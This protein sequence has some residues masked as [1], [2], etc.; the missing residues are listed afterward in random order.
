MK[1]FIAVTFCVLL[2]Q[3]LSAQQDLIIQGIVSDVPD[4]ATL[5][6]FLQ[7]GNMGVS[8]G[9]DTLRN[10]RFRFQYPL[11]GPERFSIHRKGAEHFGNDY[12]SSVV[13][14]GEP[15]STV[16]V[17]GDSPFVRTWKVESDHPEQL[18]RNRLTDES[19]EAYIRLEK[20]DNQ[21]WQTRQKRNVAAPEEQTLLQLRV[22]S[23]DR[24]RD[25][26]I[27]EI[28]SNTLGL[29]EHTDAS[30]LWW[31]KLT[32]ISRSLAGDPEFRERILSIY[33]ELT[34]EVRDQS[35]AR[36]IHSIL[37]PPDKIGV[38]EQ[39][40]DAELKEHGAGMRKLSE[41]QGKYMLLDFW[42][43][44]C[45]AFYSSMPEL[46]IL[47]EKL[48]DSLTIVGI[49]LDNSESAWQFSIDN[50]GPVTWTN[51]NAP[52]GSDVAARYGINAYPTLFLVSPGGRILES[53]QGHHP[54]RIEEE[55]KKYQALEE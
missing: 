17:R 28:Y 1:T 53:W 32:T 20:T 16:I 23:L 47:S 44:G 33:N 50:F 42:A 27:R 22:D 8:V 40:A 49:N 6:L 51:L 35:A 45:G 26:I 37:F 31:A 39:M 24:E 7:H 2:T 11:E 18:L 36:E 48:T 12:S 43:S 38:G 30:P 14:W 21:N 19:R 54:G 9:E 46:R 4:G 5:Q 15:G 29:L 34:D 13:I 25:L 3:S 52:P 41:F 10:G 55:L